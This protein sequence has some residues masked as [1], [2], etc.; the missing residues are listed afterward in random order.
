MM[1]RFRHRFR[2]RERQ[3]GSVRRLA[4]AA[5]L[6]SGIASSSFRRNMSSTKIDRNITLRRSCGVFRSSVTCSASK[7]KTQSE[8]DVRRARAWRQT[9]CSLRETLMSSRLTCVWGSASASLPAWLSKRGDRQ[10][11]G[12]DTLS[13]ESSRGVRPGLVIRRNTML[14]CYMADFLRLFAPHLSDDQ[15]ERVARASSQ[16][17][18]DQLVSG[19]GLPIRNGFNKKLSA[20]A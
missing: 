15:I 7:A 5:R 17:E 13:T 12:C 4:P 14:R 19:A 2:N 1:S 3:R 8:R 18:V 10:T 16:D 20:A 9:S 11:S 6:T